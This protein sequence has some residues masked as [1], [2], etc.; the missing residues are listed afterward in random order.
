MR[1]LSLLHIVAGLSRFHGG[2]SYSV[3]RLC[4]SLQELSVNVQIFTLEEPH[5]VEAEYINAFSRDFK[6]L[7]FL[8][9]LSLSSNLATAAYKHAIEAD[10]IHVH[11]MWLMPNIYAGRAAAKNNKPLIVSPRGMLT[12]PALSYAPNKKKLF[13]KFLQEPAY[14]RAACWHA[15]SSEEARD[16][17]NFGIRAPIAII[18]NGIDVPSNIQ[19][20]D[21]LKSQK[22]ILFLG[23]LH[24]KKGVDVLLDA[25]SEIAFELPEWRVRIIGPNESGYRQEMEARLLQLG[26]PR[27]TF[28]DAIFNT[29]KQAAFDDADVFVL[30]TRT[31]NFGI[32]VAEAL[33]SGTPAIVSKSAPW[34]GLNSEHCGW[35]INEGVRPLVEALRAATNLSDAERQKMGERGRAF[36]KREFDWQCVAQKTIEV[37]RWISGRDERPSFV[38]CD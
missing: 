7:P 27:V 30:P 13:W 33:A 10:V 31:E 37:Y 38:I 12:S 1:N 21:F 20:I 8:R 9:D 15:T 2:P 26:A 36:V 3:P 19:K 34:S 28:E 16:L 11:G 18:P 4:R 23:R 6:S 32:S 35:W 22:T 14:R 29:E 5:T 25:W 24:P 17:R